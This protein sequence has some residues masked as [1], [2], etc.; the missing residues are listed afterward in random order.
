MGENIRKFEETLLQ[1]LSDNAA[2]CSQTF[3]KKKTLFFKSRTLLSKLSKF[4]IKARKV[5]L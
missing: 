4:R 3:E 5:Y 1:W 2:I